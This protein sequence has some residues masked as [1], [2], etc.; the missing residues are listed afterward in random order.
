MLPIA[1]VVLAVGVARAI[2]LGPGSGSLKAAAGPEHE[3]HRAAASER[4]PRGEDHDEHA[5][6]GPPP[7]ALDDGRYA[8]R[9]DAQVLPVGARRFSFR[10]LDVRAG[11]PVTRFQDDLTKKLH[12]IVVREDLT[13]FQ[14]IHPRMARD[15]RWTATGATLSRA[16]PWRLIADFIPTGAK[17][18]VLATSVHA[19]GGRYD[20]RPLRESPRAGKHAW[21]TSVDGYDVLLRADDYAG[22]RSGKL[23]FAVRRGGRPVADL[24]PY[25]GA[26]GHAVLLRWGDVGY[27]HVHPD[28]ERARPGEIA[29]D[30]TYPRAAAL[31]LFLQFRHR[32]RVHTAKFALPVAPLA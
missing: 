22:G 1:V 20:V 27:V 13:G 23:H 21:R 8:L 25:L 11:R 7:A 16:G 24:Q 30:V 15:G 2:D 5:A 19:G 10:I 26:L 32:D 6:S 28:K 4:K 29:F 9:L 18:A 17:R 31:A 12:L 14:H 3:R